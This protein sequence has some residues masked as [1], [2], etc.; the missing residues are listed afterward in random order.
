MVSFDTN[1]RLKLWSKDRARA[2]ITDMMGRCDI[3]LPS[4]DDV[5]ALTG[6]E[7]DDAIVDFA[8]GRGARIVAKSLCCTML[9]IRRLPAR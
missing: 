6:I 7:Q 8:L 4:Y 2:V 3:C 9:F 1:L 5:F